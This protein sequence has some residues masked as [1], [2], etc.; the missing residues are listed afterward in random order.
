VTV[1]TRHGTGQFGATP[2]TVAELAE[3][4]HGTSRMKL[5]EPL[6]SG[7]WIRVRIDAVRAIDQ[8]YR[9]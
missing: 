6:D 1:L 8:Q 3:I 5:F 4:V 7:V 2:V 9:P